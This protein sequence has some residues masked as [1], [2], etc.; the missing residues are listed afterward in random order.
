MD[1]YTYDLDSLI[2]MSPQIV[3]GKLGSEHR[4]NNVTVREL[5]IS[6]VHKGI[7]KAGQSIDVRMSLCPK[8][9]QAVITE[10]FTNFYK[11][12]KLFAPA[13][14]LKQICKSAFAF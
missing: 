14:I 12:G 2:Y 3:E 1:L 5:K 9:C 8:I 13:I 6:A 11:K 4:T 7:L 10:Y